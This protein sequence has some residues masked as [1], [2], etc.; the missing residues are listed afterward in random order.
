MDAAHIRRAGPEDVP[1][2]ARIVNDWIDRTEWMPRTYPRETIEGFVAEALPVR[3]IFLIGEP[4]EGYL[5]LDP[6]SG[7]I[8]ALYLDRPGQGLGKALLDRAKS[9]RR[10]LQLWTHAPNA[11]AHRFYRR[12]GFEAVER[13]EAG[14]DGLPEIRM[15]WQG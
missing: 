14:G 15:E 7:M 8:G 9:G 13:R 6:E 12:E 3:E 11:A 5:S 1:A 10:Y 4:P 2:I